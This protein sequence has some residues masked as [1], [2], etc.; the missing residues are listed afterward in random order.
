M[1]QVPD[2]VMNQLDQVFVNIDIARYTRAASTVIL[3][4]DWF[5]TFSTE[6]DLVWRNPGWRIP[7]LLFL[8][9]SLQNI[10]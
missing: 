9:V 10:R 1:R 3:L 6:V 5:L 8:V 2:S 7:S 4:Y